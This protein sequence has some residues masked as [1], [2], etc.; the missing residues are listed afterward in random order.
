MS[1]KHTTVRV[2]KRSYKE[3]HR[4]L[5]P[6]DLHVVYQPLVELRTG[7]IFAYEALVRWKTLQPPVKPGATAAT[8]RSGSTTPWVFRKRSASRT[9][10]APSSPPSSAPSPRRAHT[11]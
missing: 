10:A 2:V 4:E 9:R 1:D 8:K 7:V 6:E 11:A 3:L 5:L